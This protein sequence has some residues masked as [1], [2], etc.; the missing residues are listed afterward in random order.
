MTLQMGSTWPMSAARVSERSA[1]SAGVI[2]AALAGPT[3]DAADPRFSVPSNDFPAAACTLLPLRVS[4]TET[5]HA[6]F[7]M[8][9]H[10]LFRAA[11]R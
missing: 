10:L 2:D 8:L 9:V 7:E 11:A 1:Y 5:W 3:C 4:R 6:Q